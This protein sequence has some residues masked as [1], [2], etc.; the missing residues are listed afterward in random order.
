MKRYIYT[1]ASM[2]VLL[3]LP[4]SLLWYVATYHV[5]E[6]FYSGL[7]NRLWLFVLYNLIMLIVFVISDKLSKKTSLKKTNQEQLKASNNFIVRA[8]LTSGAP[9][10]GLASIHGL[11][12]H[13]FLKIRANT[14]G[15]ANDLVLMFNYFAISVAAVLFVT[16]FIELSNQETP[17]STSN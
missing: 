6:D 3:F 1:A 14:P 10:M 15:C 13:R 8:L 17:N 9:L 12:M 11:A 2:N 5:F 16:K 4:F 7:L